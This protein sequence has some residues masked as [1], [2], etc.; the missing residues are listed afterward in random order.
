MKLN[1]LCTLQ[2]LWDWFDMIEMPHLIFLLYGTSGGDRMDIQEWSRM[3]VNEMWVEI[4]VRNSLLGNV[5]GCVWRQFRPW[6]QRL[7]LS[8]EGLSIPIVAIIVGGLNWPTSVLCGIMWLSLP[9][10]ILGTTPVEY[11]SS[12]RLASPALHDVSQRWIWQPRVFL[13]W[14]GVYNHCFGR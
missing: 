3:M 4:I 10:I 13:G 5:G 6:W 11:F 8:Q 7:V 14:Y 1:V 2:C 12:C 9:Q